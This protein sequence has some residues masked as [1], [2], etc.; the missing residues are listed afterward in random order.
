M[1]DLFGWLLDSYT[2]RTML[3]GTFAVG[4]VTGLLGCILYCRRQ[5]MIADVVGHGAL[6]G[7]AVAFLV[8]VAWLGTDGR[9]LPVIMAG[10]AVAGLIAMWL[11]SRIAA[12]TSLGTDAAMAVMIALLFGGGMVLMRYI[13]FSPLPGRGGLEKSLFGNAATLTSLDLKA[14][15]IV[16]A[17]VVVA[18]VVFF[19]PLSVVLFDPHYAMTQGLASP[20]MNATITVLVIAGLVVGA[21]AIGIMMMLGF[22]MLPPASAVQWARDPKTMML[23]SAL[24]GA[25]GGVGGSVV[26]IWMGEVPTG[27]VAIVM[28]FAAFMV[29]VC[30]GRRSW[31]VAFIGRRT[32]REALS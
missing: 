20:R 14:V 19:R 26:A 24:F 3:S 4:T 13:T 2:Y 8:A 10:A 9:S 1:P 6:G 31:I 29:S 11:T 27:P 23:L 5:T 7:V 16:G 25:F 30:V 15:W 32:Q 21:K 28:L 12:T 17:V 18:L 22:V